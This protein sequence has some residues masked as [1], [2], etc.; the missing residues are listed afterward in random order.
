MSDLYAATITF[1]DFALKISEV[2]KKLIECFGEEDSWEESY[3]MELHDGT[4]F[5]QDCD[6]VDGEF[7][8]VEKVFRANGIPFDRWSDSYAG[9]GSSTLYYRPE[10]KEDVF[11]DGNTGEY[12]IP[13]SEIQRIIDS[14]NL[15]E[16]LKQMLP[17]VIKDLSEYKEPVKVKK[18]AKA[19]AR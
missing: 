14:P 2:R 13:A 3:D 6:A 1:P 8:C 9:I 11:V 19:S 15:K 16:E 12:M 7:E 18:A 4:V 5:L 10:L 17:P